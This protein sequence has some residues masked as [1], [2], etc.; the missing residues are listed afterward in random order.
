[1]MPVLVY[2]QSN[3]TTLNVSGNIIRK[4]QKSRTLDE[5]IFKSALRMP[6]LIRTIKY[7]IY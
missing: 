7:I 6:S 1:M 3:F 2:L 4:K 5:L